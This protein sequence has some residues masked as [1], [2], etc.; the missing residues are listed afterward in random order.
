MVEPLG[1]GGIAH[2]TFCLATALSGLGVDVTLMTA[3]NYELAAEADFQF[4]EI[5]P[6]RGWAAR[7]PF[8]PAKQAA[9]A[10]AVA[11]G[12][13]KLTTEINIR[14]PAV[15]HLQG[16]LVWADRLFS[17]S[18]SRAARAGGAKTVYTAH[19]ILPHEVKRGDRRAYRKIYRESDLLI[20]HANEN[21]PV[22]AALEPGHARTEIIPHGN[23][24]FLAAGKGPNK[25][26]A[27]RALGLSD[28]DK[29]I[30]FFGVVRPY[31]G[32]DLLIE[33]FAELYTEDPGA[34]LVIA[35]N[36][37]GSTEIYENLIKRLGLEASVTRKW[38]YIA[39]EDI[40]GFFCAADVVALPYRDTYQS[41]VIHTA[42]AFGLPVVASDVGGLRSIVEQGSCGV[43]VPAGDVKA[44]AR[45]LKE[46][47]GDPEQTARMGANGR[48]YAKTEASW[49]A[50][51]EK[52]AAAY[53]VDL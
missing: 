14:K 37:L 43:L 29:V 18:P 30:L 8:A 51:A 31:K 45:G 7:I 48:N 41:G 23:Y 36:P 53:G 10:A 11:A 3:D 25:A 34:R 35:G 13:R 38:S 26:D 47:L 19:N 21:M 5:F 16:S 12:M 6:I 20:V 42:L 4:K 39:N 32:L 2:Y 15:V 50:I 1:R 9:K 52:T 46:L 49:S 22:L 27:R 40:P 17:M 44:L 24:D 33:A 28:K